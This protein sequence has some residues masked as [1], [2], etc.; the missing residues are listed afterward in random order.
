M[1]VIHSLKSGFSRRKNFFL[2]SYDIFK[3]HHRALAHK[4]FDQTLSKKMVQFACCILKQNPDMDYAIFQHGSV[5]IK[6]PLNESF[7]DQADIRALMPSSRS[8]YQ[9]EICITCNA[10]PL[11]S[12]EPPPP[13]AMELKLSTSLPSRELQHFE[14]CQINL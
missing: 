9:A 1:V 8:F 2:Y 11:I 13:C 14:C 7:N 10:I 5:E 6:E 4:Y 3:I 12:Y